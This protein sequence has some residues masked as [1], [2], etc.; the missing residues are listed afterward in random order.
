M[1]RKEGL[2]HTKAHTHIW[3]TMMNHLLACEQFI[4]LNLEL[5]IYIYIY[6]VDNI[7]EIVV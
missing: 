4:I 7:D 1:I 6:I 3:H 5:C 2:T